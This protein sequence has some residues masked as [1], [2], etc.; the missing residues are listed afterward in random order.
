MNR[1]NGADADTPQT[2]VKI[3]GGEEVVRNSIRWQISLRKWGH[4]KCGG[5]IIAADRILTA[6]HCVMDESRRKR[7][8]SN[9][10]CFLAKNL[11][12][13]AG[14]HTKGGYHPDYDSHKQAIKVRSFCI[15]PGI[16]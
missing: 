2:G 16:L 12:I 14:T 13:Y 7:D 10:R 6:A 11:E 15:H 3:V 5:S 8:R 9:R 1:T 4:P